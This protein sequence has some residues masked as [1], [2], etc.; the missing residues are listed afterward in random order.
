MKKPLILITLFAFLGMTLF[1]QTST[2]TGNVTTSEDG[3]ALPGVAVVVKN[4]TVGTVTDLDGNYS[5]VVPQNAEKLVFMFVGM[6]TVEMDIGGQS[7]IDLVM[8]PDILGLDE[9]VVT[10][11]ASGTATKK[12]GFA[13]TKVDKDL[14]TEVPAQ[15]AS[16]TLRAKV[17][18]IT[19]VQS[20]G[21][22]EASVS[23]RGAKS[24]YGNIS[25]LIIIDGILTKQTLGDLNPSDIESI[26][27]VKG[28]AASSLYGSL[29][30]GGVIQVRTKRGSRAKGVNVNLRAEYGI[31]SLPGEYPAATKHPFMVD[32]SGP[33]DWY[34]FDL[35]SGGRLFDDNGGTEVNQWHDFS[36][37]YDNI[38]ALMSNQP[39]QSYY[40]SIST[41]GDQYAFFGSV[42]YTEKG[43]L[44]AILDPQKRMNVRMNFDFFPTQKLTARISTSY[45]KQTYE[46][47]T[48]GDQGTF[49]A[50][51][52]QI[53]PF[54]DLTQ[55]DADG[56]YRV[57]PDGFTVTSGNIFNPMYSYSTI[58][59]D[60]GDDR[61]VAGLDLKYQFTDAISASF[62][63][64]IDMKWYQGSTYYP[65]GY[66]TAVPSATLNNGNYAISTNRNWYNVTTAQLNYIKSFGDFNV[67]LV[68][69][70]LYELEKYDSYS[71]SGYNLTTNGVYDLGITQQD[72]RSIDSY[73]RKDVTMNYFIS[74]DVD[75]RDKI[76][77]NGMFR[78]DGSSRFGP[79]ER[80][81]SFWRG[82]VAWRIT[83]DFDIPGFNELK[84]RV[85]YGT[86]GRRPSF[87]G[88]YETYS[89]S[90][91]GISGSQLGN[92]NLKPAIN[93]ELEVGLDGAFLE[94]FTFQINYAASTVKNDYF[95]R[96]L[97]AVTGFSSQ[98]QNLGEIKS[99]SFEIQFGATAV[100]NQNFAWDL[101]FTFDRIRSEITDLA[102]VPGFTSGLY[103]VEEGQPQGIMYGQEYMTALDQLATDANGFVTNA[104]SVAYDPTDA[105]VNT[106]ISDFVVNNVGYVVLD[107]LIGTPGEFAVTY[108]DAT[109]NKEQRIIGDRNADFKVG[110]A[111]TF[112]FF[113]NLQLYILLDW[114]QGGDKYNQTRQYMHFNWRQQDQVDWS[115]LGHHVTF[116]SSASSIYNGNNYSS[117]YVEDATYLKLR[118]LSLSYTFNNVAN[119]F[120]RIRLSVIGRNLLT[121]TNYSSYDPEGYYE[122]FNYPTFKTFTGSLQVSF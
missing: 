4:T 115:A 26:E 8:E 85:S 36:R 14:L 113:K 30:A 5:L 103:R 33:A 77:V 121:F 108:K 18:G 119:F 106:N 78:R 110:F 23:L 118:E 1:A 114:K 93:T 84:A 86:A 117:A 92:K 95:Q 24:I 32:P 28:A 27:V 98:Y 76:I 35:S 74:A 52:L 107:S 19:I 79:D 47:V 15:D 94:R 16:G 54:I 11:V 57:T 46:T 97:S 21:D 44:V 67:G 17:A 83:E 60:N 72:G 104:W 71:A 66:K 49:F 13:M 10:G 59:R 111:N 65:K 25:P 69:K 73:Q 90:S 51:T 82:S 39:Y 120:D 37:N 96:P 55:K 100:Q 41:S 122:Q 102:G 40:A 43:N 9:V 81:Q 42:D 80:W 75:W 3:A 99:S 68:G 63:Q 45:T 105:A 70:W 34:G 109:G 56:D 88:Q 91:S 29:A 112:T 6:K 116:S 58:Q 50:M 31:A 87:S 20:N 101:N 22:Q 7:T 53:E 48:R 2:I 38:N 62:T 12:L 64:S 61:F 89:V